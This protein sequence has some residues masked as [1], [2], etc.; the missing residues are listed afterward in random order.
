M[1][2]C[3]RKSKQKLLNPAS[4]RYCTPQCKP[5]LPP[6]PTAERLRDGL[7]FVILGPPNA[8][9][10]TLLNALAG[11]DIAIV[12]ETPGTTRDTISARL[13]LAGIPVHITDTAGLRETTNPIE[14]E[15]IR[16]AQSSAA[17]ADLI[18]SLAAPG[19]NFAPTP[20]H[21]KTLHLTTKSDLAPATQTPH[22]ISAKTGAGL[23]TLLATLTTIAQRLT[24]TQGAPSLARPRQIAC[25]RDTA[26]ALASALA[27]PEPELRAEDLRT[28]ATALARLTGTIGIEEILDAVFNS[29]CIG[30]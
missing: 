29:F 7:E 11:S 8:G 22:Q 9:K 16:R 20:P 25:I 13:D 4:Q 3:P 6:P 26:A 19:Q 30:K 17:K 12:S 2:T 1:K 5:H 21:I 15:G 14:T 27:T 24:D 28:A 10:S 18:I 23:Q